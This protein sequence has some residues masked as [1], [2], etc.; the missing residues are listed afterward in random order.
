MSVSML[1]RSITQTLPLIREGRSVKADEGLL[2]GVT[3]CAAAF[4]NLTGLSG[5]ASGVVIY[6]ASAEAATT[7]G[8]VRNTLPCPCLPGKL[9][10][11]VLTVTSPLP[12]CPTCPAAQPAHPA[13]ETSA[14]AFLNISINP[15]ARHSLHTSSVAGLSLIHISE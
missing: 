15:S 6:P 2:F 14:P 7:A 10:L 12:F 4:S 11:P 1:S 3:C 9:R 8:E 13:L 5:M